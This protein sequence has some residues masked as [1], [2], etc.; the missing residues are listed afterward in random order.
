MSRE[1][2]ESARAVSI[3]EKVFKQA[4]QRTRCKPPCCS[5]RSSQQQLIQLH[6]CHGASRR[7]LLLFFVIHPGRSVL[8]NAAELAGETGIAVSA[9]APCSRRARC[10]AAVRDTRREHLALA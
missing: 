1:A 8:A 5:E 4:Y 10:H 6:S 9:A 7:R 2:E 3:W